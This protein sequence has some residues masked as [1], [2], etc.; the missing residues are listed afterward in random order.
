MRS[1]ADMGTIQI[2]IT[3]ACTLQCSNCTR[4][5][6]NH[7]K[8]FFMNY[9]DFKKAVDSVE[10]FNGVTGVMGGEPTLH[11]EFERFVLYLQKKFG[12]RRKENRLLYPQKDF[13]WEIRRRECESCVTRER[14]DGSRY[15]KSHGPGLWSNM[16]A[17]YLKYY[18]I[19]QDTFE[20]QYLN[21]HMNPSYHQPGLFSRKDL[22]IP[23]EEWIPIRDACW[24]QNEWSATIT[25]K[26]AF[27]CEIAGALDMLFDGPGG[28]KVE[29]GWWK[30]TPEEFGD[31]L[32]WCEICGFALSTFV[33]NAEESIDDV[34]P[35]VYEMLKKVDSP[36]YKSG[37]INPVKINN[38]VIADES[39]AEVKAFTSYDR[40]M[41]H[42]EDRF[43]KNNSILFQCE[44]T[45]V[46]IQNGDIF[47]KWLNSL[48]QGEKEWILLK[49]DESVDV[50]LVTGLIGKTI[51]NPGSLVVGEGFLFFCKRALSIREMG[52]VAIAHMKNE[53]EFME[54]WQSD[55]IVSL[56]D[57]E[58]KTKLKRPSI[59]A[60]KRYALWGA[61]LYG[62]FISDAVKG[63]GGLLTVIADK[64]E[65]KQGEKFAGIEVVAPEYLK[66]HQDEYDLL[67]I[68]HFTRF[69]EIEREAISLGLLKEKIRLPY[70]L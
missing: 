44:Y 69:E 17:S 24:I 59:Q 3:N 61:G 23:D 29:P 36:K 50:S 54:A 14:E 58:E 16:S 18:E 63:S 12:K 20:V 46:S 25:P 10:G 5:C 7:K 6:G 66:D 9:E 47:G 35:T 38:G 49:K 56:R 8:P 19:I 53:K 70:E 52:H 60:G 45:E 26:G 37:R 64:S 34:S 30:R 31:Q 41:E 57:L 1:P 51:W 40:Y 32:H 28:W 42:Y 65:E 2:D 62:E 4:F 15:V 27:F 13:I 22:G 33:R 11:P 55:K 67:I 68:S 48:F 21:D 43:N 39:K